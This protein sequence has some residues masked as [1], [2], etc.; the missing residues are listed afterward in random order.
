MRGYY[1]A[2]LERGFS[3]FDREQW[4]VLEFK[5]FLADH[6]GAMNRLT[7]FLELDRFGEV[8]ELPHGMQNKPLV[9]GTAPTGAD[10]EG[11]LKLYREDFERFKELSGLDVSHWPT[12]QLV[13]GTLDP[14]AL[15]ARF[16]AKVV[17]AQA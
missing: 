14:D 16:A 2:Q 15:A 3:L 6:E 9:P 5:A 12:Q 8:P 10:I 1:G 4:H 11:L 17:P 13:A 7:D